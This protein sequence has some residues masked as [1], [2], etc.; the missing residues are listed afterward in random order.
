MLR[1]SPATTTKSN[2]ELLATSQSS[3]GSV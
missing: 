1:Q 3:W 2:A